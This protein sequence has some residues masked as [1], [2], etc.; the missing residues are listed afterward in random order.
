MDN[1]KQPSSYQMLVLIA[2]PKLTDKAAEMFVKNNVPIQYRLSAEGTAS[3]E[4]MDTLGLGS[5]DKGLLVSMVPKSFGNKMLELLHSQLRLD[6]VNSG[7]AF[8][9]P[10]TGASNIMLRIMNA[11]GEKS[12]LPDNGK[13]E[14]TMTEKKYALIAAIVDRGCGSDVM[15]AAREAGAGGGTIIHSRGIETDEAT[16]FW[17]LSLQE[18]KQIVLILA[19][20][21]SKVKIM[22]AISE[23][24]GMN[25]KAKGIVVSLP[26]DSVMGI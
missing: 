3:S 16:G 21:E 13:G 26:I 24:C 19:K 5:I 7:I 23:K 2:T 22:S 20:H 14:N 15:D 17:G 1:N 11:T 4:I 6:S 8:T 25:T 18:E 12:E 10:L 9:M